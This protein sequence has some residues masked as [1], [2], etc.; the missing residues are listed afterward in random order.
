MSMVDTVTRTW[1]P[2]RPRTWVGVRIQIA[3]GLA[4]RIRALRQGKGWSQERLAEEAEMH[5]TYLAGIEGAHRNPGRR[6]ARVR[7]IMSPS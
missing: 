4:L 7:V 2:I 6:T 1:L 3:R 5:R